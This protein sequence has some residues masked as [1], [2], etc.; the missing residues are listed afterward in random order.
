MD[1]HFIGCVARFLNASSISQL[2]LIDTVTKETPIVNSGTSLFCI[3][4]HGLPSSVVGICKKQLL[5]EEELGKI[6]DRLFKALPV[7]SV[8]NKYLLVPVLL[9]LEWLS[10]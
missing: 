2:V 5:S 7:A 3:Y 6:V 8:L 9:P 4:G 10:V 1:E